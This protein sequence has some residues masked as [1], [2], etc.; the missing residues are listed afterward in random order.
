MVGVFRQLFRKK[1][2]LLK[3]LYSKYKN[4]IPW[5]CYFCASKTKNAD[6]FDK[7]KFLTHNKRRG[8][9]YLEFKKGE[10]K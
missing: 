6:F 7:E 1:Q 9:K 4:G 3:R 2:S 10:A 8:N 5:G